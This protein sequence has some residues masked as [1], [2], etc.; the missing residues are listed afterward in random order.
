MRTKTKALVAGA[1]LASLMF[2]GL[3]P[4]L[5]AQSQQASP[6]TTTVIQ[7]AQAAQ[8]YAQQILSIAKQ[9]GVNVTKQQNLDTQGAQLLIKAQNETSSNADAAIRDALNA[10]NDFRDSAQSL[11]EQI[12]G[13]IL[14]SNDGQV[15]QMQDLIQRALNKTSELEAVV[16]KAC[17]AQGAPTNICTDAKNN[18]DQARTDLTQASALLKSNQTDINGVQKLVKD[19]AQHLNQVSQDLNSLATSGRV[20]KAIELINSTLRPR[21]AQERQ[22]VQK[23]NLSTTQTQQLLGQLDQAQSLLNTAVQTLPTDWNKGTQEVQQAVEIMTQVEQQLTTYLQ[24]Q[25]GMSFIQGLQD[26]LAQDEKAV[27]K[28]N[29]TST[30]AQQVQQQ[31]SQAKSLLDGAIQSIQKGDFNSAMKQAQ[32]AAQLLGQIEQE[33]SQ[34]VHK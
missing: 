7:V 20:E 34:N 27:Q 24:Q 18:L 3:V 5:A 19:A 31:L 10:M 32:Q 6:P 29:L 30:I 15:A 17:G 33:L 8:A 2:S 9:N 14:N 11:Q 28:A 16:T 12:L 4:A 1:I 22:D 23:A 25:K 13:P 21:L 26:R